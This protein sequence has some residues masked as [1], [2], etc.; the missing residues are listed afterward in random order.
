M[1]KG[2]TW[3]W[4]C[5]QQLPLSVLHSQDF[6]PPPHPFPLEYT[7]WF[8]EMYNCVSTQNGTSILMRGHKDWA[9]IFPQAS[10]TS[11]KLPKARAQLIGRRVSFHAPSTHYQIMNLVEGSPV[12]SPSGL[13]KLVWGR[14]MSRGGGHLHCFCTSHQT[15]ICSCMERIN[16]VYPR[17]FSCNIKSYP[18]APAVFIWMFTVL[19]SWESSYWEPHVS[20]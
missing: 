11:S 13:R 18:A 5:S 20:C 19:R 7:L 8:G 3:G 14:E 1:S 10:A 2:G 4:G 6:E 17:A 16:N 9:V 15:R 12:F